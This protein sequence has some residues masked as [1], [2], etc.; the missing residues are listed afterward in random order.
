MHVKQKGHHILKISGKKGSSFALI[1]R[2]KRSPLFSDRQAALSP[3]LRVMIGGTWCRRP[4]SP[5]G[6]DRRGEGVRS[7]HLSP[8]SI[9]I[10]ARDHAHTGAV[11]VTN[12]KARS[13]RPRKT[14]TTFR[15]TPGSF[16]EP[17]PAASGSQAA[18]GIQSPHLGNGP[19]SRAGSP[20]SR[21]TRKGLRWEQASPV[22]PTKVRSDTC[23]RCSHWPSVLT[24]GS[25]RSSLRTSTG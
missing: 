14:K 24:R 16:L 8:G 15:S 6:Q 18:G 10:T 23:T 17:A 4:L 12:Q 25:L 19:H 20:P 2:V 7:P 9:H 13:A 5:A 21:L 3:S 1:L 22:L 11:P